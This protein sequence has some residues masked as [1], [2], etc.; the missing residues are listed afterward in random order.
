MLSY[1]VFLYSTLQY[2]FSTSSAV[3]AADLF[4]PQIALAIG[5]QDLQVDKG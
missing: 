4:F 5:V 1:Y 2:C 3:S